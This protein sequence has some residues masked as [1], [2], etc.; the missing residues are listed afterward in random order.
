MVHPLYN[1]KILQHKNR[2][3]PLNS[4]PKNLLISRYDWTATIPCGTI[5]RKNIQNNII[6]E[7]V[8]S[9]LVKLFL[10]LEGVKIL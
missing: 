7:S 8:L 3:H 5:K 10:E 9:K 4:N 1:P 2:I 6:C